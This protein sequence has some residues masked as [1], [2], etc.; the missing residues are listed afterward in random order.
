MKNIIWLINQSLVL[1]IKFMRVSDWSLLKK[2]DFV[3]LK[4]LLVSKHFF[5]KFKLGDD[6]CYFDGKKIYYDS[7]YG[8]AGYQRLLST[9][10]NLIKL[11]GIHHSD[12]II[13]IGANVGF[14]SKLCR[15][16]FPE[17]KIFSFEPIP[18]TFQC[19]QN[20]FQ[21]DTNT[22]VFNLAISDCNGK[23]KMNFNEQ[24]S[25]VSQITDNGNVPVNVR[26][27]DDF[28]KEKNISNIDILKIDTETFEAH[29]LRGGI[30][31]LSK[32]RY[33]FMEIT[34]EEDN[35]NYTLSSLLKLLSTEKYDF[36][37]IGFR[38]YNDKGEGKILIMDALFIN[39]LLL[40][41]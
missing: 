31:S 19:L 6:F 4:Y 40:K 18:K 22:E 17:S 36:Q 14:F 15:D 33:L 37:L 8:L 24:N 38:N 41:K 7:R 28:I 20:N 29:V 32:V 34:M 1:D 5:K 27:L 3:I 26:K 12:T 10:Q 39:K 16:L 11:A 30:D 13:D 35:H 2:I 23:S 9:H 21:K 25:A